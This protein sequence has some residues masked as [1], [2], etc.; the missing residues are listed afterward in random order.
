MRS[1]PSR[2]RVGRGRAPVL[3]GLS[4]ARRFV[5]ISRQRPPVVPTISGRKDVADVLA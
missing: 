2:G 3:A 5:A 1:A 4:A